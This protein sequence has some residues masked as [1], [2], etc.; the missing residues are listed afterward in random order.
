MNPPRNP[1]SV[2]PGFSLVEVTLAIGIVGVA[3]LSLV[4]ILTSTFQQVDEI[5]QTNRA[6][7]GVTRLIGALDNPRSIVYLD[8]AGEQVPQNSKY[9]LEAPAGDTSGVDLTDG[10]PAAS[11]FDIVYRLLQ[12]AR[13]NGDNAVW[14]YVY[15][16]KIVAP[17]SDKTGATGDTAFAL[18]SNPSMMEVA[19]CSG[20]NLTINSA[21]GRNIIG[22]PMRVRLSLSKLL[23][24]QRTVI[25]ATTFEPTTAKVAAAPWAS[26]PLPVKPSGYAL[27]YLPL[28][29]E[30]F[31]HD[32]SPY[33]S[34]KTKTENPLLV[35]NIVISR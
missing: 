4:G 28:V 30:F 29:A 32:Y 18:Y 26:T 19:L 16:R 23:V 25:D 27:A 7:A 8:A 5:M 13:D 3:I 11:N 2:R 20:K 1:S 34:F 9:L 22:I 6:L 14:L 12:K 10:N 35:Q 15:E 17:D 24:G 31:P 21:F 33:D